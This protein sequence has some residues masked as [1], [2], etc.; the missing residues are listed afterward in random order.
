MCF[1]VR[2]V[3]ASPSNSIRARSMAGPKSVSPGC[4]ANKPASEPLLRSAVCSPANIRAESSASRV[5]CRH[6]SCLRSDSSASMSHCAGRSPISPTAL[7]AEAMMDVLDPQAMV[8]AMKPTNSALWGSSMNLR[9][10]EIGS[11]ATKSGRSTR[12][13]QDKRRSAT[14]IARPAGAGVGLPCLRASRNG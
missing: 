1:A 4:R 11:K 2:V 3:I 12:S 9:G 6:G 8:A 7:S 14:S 13:A 10:R 5:R